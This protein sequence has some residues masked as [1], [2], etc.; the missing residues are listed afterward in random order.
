MNIVPAT[1]EHYER[2]YGE[3]SVYSMRGLTVFEDDRIIGIGGV[4][5]MGWCWVAFYKNEGM[6]KRQMVIGGRAYMKL[7]EGLGRSIYTAP[8]DLVD[9]AD[10]LLKHLNF[11][12][13]GDFWQWR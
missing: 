12:D 13:K 5:W 9:G 6:T 2:V 8:D 10:I 3:P 11:E 4:R 7:L 1:A